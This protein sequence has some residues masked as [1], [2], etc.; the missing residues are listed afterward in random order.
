MIPWAAFMLFGLWLGRQALHDERLVWTLCWRSLALF[1]LVHLA[2]MGPK[3]LFSGETLDPEAREFFWGTAPMPPMPLYMA[4][5]MAIA[6][7]VITAC[8]MLGRRF[9]Q[10]FLLRALLQTGQ[11]ALTF[12]VAHVVLGMGLL[13][14]AAPGSLGTYP[15][16]FSM[17]YALVFMLLCVGFAVVWLKY[18]RMGPLEWGMR[19]LTDS[20]PTFWR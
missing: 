13:E 7:C 16:E 6:C 1:A 12:Y 19:K 10:H 14:V 20:P 5:G 4:N 15:L 2:S 17:G 3:G 18:W 11:L 8:I 9:S